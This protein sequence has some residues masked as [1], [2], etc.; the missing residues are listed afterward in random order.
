MQQPFDI[1]IGDAHYAVFPEG[2]EIY[3][4]FKDGKEYM[5]IQKD[6]ETHWLKLDPETAIPLFEPNDEVDRI[7]REI[8]EFKEEEEEDE[9]VGDEDDE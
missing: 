7:G 8:L 6:A 5:Q 4:I 3:T 1:N 9:E 2:E